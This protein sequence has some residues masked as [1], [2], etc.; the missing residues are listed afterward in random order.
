VKTTHI[1]GFIFIIVLTIGVNR[2]IQ[3][4]EPAPAAGP[5][6][7][8]QWL[9]IPQGVN[10]I[11]D[12]TTNTRGNHPEKERQPPLKRIADPEN[13]KSDNPAIKTAAKIK[14]EEDLA[15]QKVKA[16]KY[17]A[18]VGCSCYPGVK[19]S[20]LAALD[21]CTEE[22]RYQAAV[23]FCQIASRNCQYCHNGSCCSAD[24]MTKLD[25][26]A[27]GQDAK[28]C[29]KEASSRVRAAAE[30][31]LN[32]CR[33]KATG[34]PVPA[35]KEIPERKELPLE[36]APEPDT[37][38]RAPT[39]AK[40]VSYSPDAAGEAFI[41]DREV[42]GAVAKKTIA[43]DRASISRS[44]DPD[45]LALDPSDERTAV[46]ADTVGLLRRRCPVECPVE[47][48]PRQGAAT[49][50]ETGVGPGG[51]LPGEIGPGAAA[52]PTNALAGNFG[53]A[54]GPGSTAPNMIGDSFINGGSML[55]RGFNGGEQ[56]VVISSA[57][58]PI[59]GGDRGFKISENDSPIPRNRVFFDY[60]HFQ[61][62]IEDANFNSRNLD[63]YSFGI[64]KTFFCGNC[65]VE[66]RVPV[67]GGLDATQS[68]QPGSDIMGTELG[69]IPL[70]FKSILRRWDRAVLAGGFDVTFPTAGEAKLLDSNGN[71]QIIVSNDAF[72]ISPYLGYLWEPNP[73]WFI[74]GFAQVDF[75][76]N[77]NAVFTR[78]V[79]VVTGPTTMVKSGTY[80]DQNLLFMDLSVGR[81][82]YRN[83]CAKV[84]RGI[85]PAVE[86]HYTTTLQDTDVVNGQY[87]QSGRNPNQQVLNPLNRVDLLNLTAGLHFQF[88]GNSLL[89]VAAAAPLRINDDAEF[90]AELQVH[91]TRY[92]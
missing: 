69:N 6:T 40:S 81:W 60:N 31:A 20:L 1:T 66:L 39:A 91:F 72:H 84:L 3:A 83:P 25:D 90:D 18:E 23:A 24:V 13:L 54:A 75:N 41:D 33:S 58:V 4:Q 68:L 63:R 30:N 26:M 92:F 59:G 28:G 85:A 49:E 5:S 80:N 11:K 61:N 67:L 74:Q 2:A 21:D 12:A 22:V 27:H 35:T 53:A 34:T 65:S 77:G 76:A 64:E 15:P 43:S 86:L 57:N 37:A 55:L 45:E 78:Q 88:G 9:G 42:D 73:C 29:C 89:T 32:A 36:V 7:L 16:I 62:A 87:L 19:E 51:A 17:M 44:L 56:F 82:V 38:P 47:P 10:K 8:W 48:C 46:A 71:E 79:P 14:H 70:V 52:P 50:G